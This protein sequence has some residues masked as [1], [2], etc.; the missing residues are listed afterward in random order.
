LPVKNRSASGKP[1]RVLDVLDF[2]YREEVVV[3][4]GGFLE[5]FA[6]RFV[7]GG[8]GAVNQCAD[9]CALIFEVVIIELRDR[10][11]VGFKIGNLT[12]NEAADLGHFSAWACRLAS[13]SRRELTML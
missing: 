4:L 7:D 10:N 6:D 3:V 5:L 11:A 13:N 1:E 9:L 12:V 8:G 2:I